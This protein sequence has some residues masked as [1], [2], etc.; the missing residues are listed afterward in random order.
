VKQ[1]IAAIMLLAFYL[2]VAVSN[3][4]DKKPPKFKIKIMAD[5]WD[6]AA[7]EAGF[8]TE[9][10]SDCHLAL[11]L[12]TASTGGGVEVRSAYFAT[13]D[14]ANQYFQ[15]NLDRAARVSKQGQ[16][17]NVK[18]EHF[19]RRAVILTKANAWQLMLTGGST[20]RSFT[21]SDRQILS[22]FERQFIEPDL[23]KHGV[24]PK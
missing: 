18:G 6:Q 12:Y 2:A 4:S 9:S 8:H 5:G 23:Q 7:T 11:T 15:W 21:A 19:G 14:E 3:A 16:N 20:F 17:T 22:E 1:T 24:S 13:A 10:S